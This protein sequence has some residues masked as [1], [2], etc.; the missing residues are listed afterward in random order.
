MDEDGHLLLILHEVPQP[1]DDELRRPFLLWSLPDGTWKSHPGPGGLAALEEHLKSYATAIHAVDTDGEAAQ[2]PQEY[3]AVM[4]RA[5]PL[6]RATR[7]LLTVMEGARKARSDERRLIVLRDRAIDLE[8]AI[9]LATGDA[10]AGM[11]FSLAMSGERQACAAHAAGMEARR[12][13]RLVAFFFP[14][15]TLVAIFGMNPPR[16]VMVM[17]GFWQVIVG[18]AVAGVVVFSLSLAKGK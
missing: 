12:L 3:F 14:L 11:D 17:P 10:K 6:L 5:Q 9:D 13:N 15:A 2:E 1:E 18:G 16:E 4:R 8:R 7:N